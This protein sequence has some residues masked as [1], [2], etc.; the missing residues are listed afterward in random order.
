MGDTTVLLGVAMLGRFG[1]PLAIAG[2]GI[3]TNSAA[4]LPRDF[5]ISSRIGST[6]PKS[7]A[8]SAFRRLA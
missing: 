7:K 2:L 4:M 8:L 6:G 5:C 1:A 3:L